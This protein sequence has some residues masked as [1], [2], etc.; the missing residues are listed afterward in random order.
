[1]KHV[2]ILSSVQNVWARNT[3]LYQVS[4]SYLCEILAWDLNNI[5]IFVWLS[6][7]TKNGKAESSM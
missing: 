2:Q 5:A 6:S 1:M 7:I 4:H 3:S